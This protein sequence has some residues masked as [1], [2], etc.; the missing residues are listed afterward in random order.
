MQ[1][2]KSEIVCSQKICRLCMH[3][4]KSEVRCIGEEELGAIE[5]LAP[6]MNINI[7]KDPVVCKEYFDSVCTHNSFLKNCLEVQETIG[8]IFNSAARESQIDTSSS[9]LFVKTEIENE[10][11]DINEMEMSI[12]AESID[13]KSEEEESRDSLL[14]SSASE[15]FMKTV[16]NAEEDGCK[17]ENRST[18]ECNTKV[19]QD[20]KVFYKCDRG[21]YKTGS[22][23]R[24]IAH[25]A[26]HEN[27]S[28]AYKCES[29]E[30][31]TENKKFFQKH[32]LR[33]KDPS[34]MRM[35]RC[36]S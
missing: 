23:S 35:H 13:I 31:E 16:K 1:E 30:Y 11:F 33:H 10:G 17:H 9:D 14:Q 5:K 28:E 29:C 12:K 32:H 20:D 2:K 3:P 24:F 27:D 25:R 19:K 36:G 18:N 21:I 26:R 8:G 6:E 7:I 15:S 22:E 34:E 4:V